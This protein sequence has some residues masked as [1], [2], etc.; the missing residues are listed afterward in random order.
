MEG[1]TK[2]EI[3]KSS[4]ESVNAITIPEIT[5]GIIFGNFTLKNACMGVQPR[6]RAASESESP[7]SLI[8]G[9]T[10]KITYGKQNVVCAI[11]IAKNPMLS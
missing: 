5:P 8:R 10:F 4:R 2:Y 3:T 1:L 7:S 6:S 9:R 11:S